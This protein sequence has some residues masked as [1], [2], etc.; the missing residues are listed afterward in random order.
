CSGEGMFR[1]EDAAVRDWSKEHVISSAERQKEILKSAYRML[2]KGGVMVY[3]T[4]TLNTVE[5]EGVILDF[6]REHADMEILPPPETVRAVTR[7]GFGL[8][9]AMRLFPHE[10]N[11]EGHFACLLKKAGEE[12]PVKIKENSPFT[13]L[14]GEAKGVNE[15]LTSLGADLTARTPLRFKDTVYLVQKGGVFVKGIRY[16]RAGIPA[17]KIEEKRVEPLH[18]LALSLKRGE[19]P[20]TVS[21]PLGAKEVAQYLSGNQ[22]TYPAPFSGYGVIA[23]NGYPLGFVKAVGDQLKNKYPKGL[24]NGSL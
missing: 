8:P 4:C 17:I 10:F 9:G 6:L 14:K 5:N 12:E 18:G 23:V 2:K 16:L 15:L 24:R 7:Q 11:G 1:K 21:F 13:P 20:R 19:C 22:I 3:S